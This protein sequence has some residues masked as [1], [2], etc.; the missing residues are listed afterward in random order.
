MSF[1][2]RNIHGQRFQ[3]D[4]PGISLPAS[5]IAHLVLDADQ[6]AAS[7]PSGVHAAIADTGTEQT[8]TTNLTS[9]PYARNITATAGGT[10]GDI[11]A[12]AV[13]VYGADVAG[14]PLSETLPA[15]TADTAGTVAGQKTF[16]T[17]NR[18]VIPAHDGTG[19]TTAIGFGDVLALRS[20][21]PYDTVLLSFHNHEREATEPTVA[22]DPDE[23]AANTIKLQTALDGQPVDVWYMVSDWDAP[24]GM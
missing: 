14:N 24:S 6:A 9:P 11:G 8:V 2:P 1:Y 4:V 16:A 17:V 5:A 15:F 3:T 18:V 13:T 21:L 10:A 12:V 7:D 22:T 20:R 19:A 23:L